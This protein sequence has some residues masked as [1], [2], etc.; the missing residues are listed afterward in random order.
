ME[1]QP[2]VSVEELSAQLSDALGHLND[3]RVLQE[4]TKAV[5]GSLDL[6]RTMDAVVR[7]V[8]QASGFAI[9]VVNLLEADGTYTVVSVDGS[10]DVRR[11]LLGTSSPAAVWHDLLANA[12][13]WGSLYF[14]DH[15]QQVPDEMFAWVP[16][17]DVSDDPLAWHPHECLFAPLTAPSGDWVGILSVDLPRDGRRPG[18]VHREILELFAQH[19][20]IAIQHARL[21]SE[22]AESRNQLHHA[23]TH[24]VLT[25]LPNRA[26]LRT[27][28]EQLAE[29]G[30][31]EVGVLVIDLN[32]FKAV[33]DNAGH[34]AGDE[35]LRVV[36]DR[37]QRHVRAGDLL[38]R[39]GG[40]EFVLIQSGPEVSAALRD[41]A[42]RLGQ[43]VTAPIIT[44]SGSQRVGV[45]IGAAVGHIH[46]DFTTLLAAADADMYRVKHRCRALRSAAA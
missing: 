30:D 28:L 18:M 19:A 14:V 8:T 45:S 37:M 4:V 6:R 31:G 1:D 23:A 5:H 32:D 15:H 2:V 38:A 25:G 7:G 29:A 24:D 40:D 44:A 43:A 22:L 3:L 26:L 20:A 9:A 27:H 33:N 42:E 21:H 34:E 13:R 12:E 46:G 35:V 36:A 16:E 39:I 10:D 11:D 41:T 17:I